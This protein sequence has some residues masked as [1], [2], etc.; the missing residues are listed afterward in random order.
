MR[1]AA[2]AL[3]GTAALGVAG[4][5]YARWE[6]EAFTLRRATTPVLPTGQPPIRLLHLSDLHLVPGQA[7]KQAWVRSL[8]AL[9]PDA[10]IV[11]GDFL[12]HMDAVPHVLDTLDPL[13]DVPGA[14]VL[15]S[16]DYYAPRPINWARYLKGP[17]QLE[18]KRPMLPWADLVDGLTTNGWLDLG[19]ARATMKIDGREVD[20]RGVDDPHISR[21][22]YDEVA[23][24]FDAAADLTLGVTHAPYLRVLDAMAADGADLVLA[25]HT[26]GGQLC[27]PG[28][29]ALVTNCDLPRK[30]ARGLSAHDGSVLH[31]SAGL[32][33][34]PY[35]PVRFACRPE[36]TL[37]TLTARA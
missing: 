26:H 9:R 14:F 13:F 33:T 27:V 19:N 12:S 25:G 1:T 7:K 29:G 37:L 20:V 17:S 10:V 16:N 3:I 4:L 30:Q 2:R 21:D 31:V 8:R 6:S 5:A 11:T 23:G 36:A 28:V 32:G 35:A 24:P 15:G 18:P 22:R 34:S